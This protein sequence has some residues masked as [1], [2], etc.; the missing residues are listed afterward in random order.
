MLAQVACSFPAHLSTECLK[1]F[2]TTILGPNLTLTQ[3]F[4][5]RYV[6]LPGAACP[7]C[8]TKLRIRYTK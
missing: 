8:F 2:T 1:A 5:V 3:L 4:A 6:S 7:W